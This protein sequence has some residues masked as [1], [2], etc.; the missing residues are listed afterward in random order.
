MR[1]SIRREAERLWIATWYQS[2]AKIYLF[3]PEVLRSVYQPS[4]SSLSTTALHTC[5]LF[6]AN[7]ASSALEAKFIC[8]P[9]FLLLRRGSMSFTLKRYVN[10]RV[11]PIKLSLFDAFQGVP[12]ARKKKATNG[13]RYEFFAPKPFPT[14]LLCQNL[15]TASKWVQRPPNSIFV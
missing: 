2:S 10:G 3:F 14:V 6:F 5:H 4:S 11:V 1:I 15:C 9:F 8:L 7:P 12:P 13:V